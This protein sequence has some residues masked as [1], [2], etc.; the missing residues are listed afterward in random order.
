LQ[1]ERFLLTGFDGITSDLSNGLA[2]KRG[3]N[4]CY[5]VFCIYVV[6]FIFGP[7]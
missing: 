7:F 3:G 4:L 6:R 5:V 2:G 1:A